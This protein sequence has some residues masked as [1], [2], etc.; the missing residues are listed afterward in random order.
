MK[1]EVKKGGSN[2]SHINNIYIVQGKEGQQDGTLS[3]TS[4]TMDTISYNVCGLNLEGKVH[5]LHYFFQGLS[6]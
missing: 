2:F 5:K 4:Q 1:K 3:N 6:L